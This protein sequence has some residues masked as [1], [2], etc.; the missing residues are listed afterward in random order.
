MPS[1]PGGWGRSASWSGQWHICQKSLGLGYLSAMMIL[2]QLLTWDDY[3]LPIS[4]RSSKMAKEVTARKH[5][6]ARSWKLVRNADVD[7]SSS[8]STAVC[9]V[10]YLNPFNHDSCAVVYGDPGCS[11]V[12]CVAECTACVSVNT[13]GSYFPLCRGWLGGSRRLQ[14]NRSC[15]CNT[16]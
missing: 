10:E 12:V 11:F 7:I 6:A 14:L 16:R 3:V 5:L 13:V 8:L 1:L 2:Q 9:S 4:A 15:K